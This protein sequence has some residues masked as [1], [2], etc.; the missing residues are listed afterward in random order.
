MESK[1][2]FT[3]EDV[4]VT[5]CHYAEQCQD[6]PIFYSEPLRVSASNITDVQPSVQLPEQ[7]SLQHHADEESGSVHVATP[8]QP[9]SLTVRSRDEIQLITRQREQRLQYQICEESLKHLVI[10]KELGQKLQAAPQC[11]RHQSP[12]CLPPL[13]LQTVQIRQSVHATSTN[14]GVMM[15]DNSST[16]HESPLQVLTKKLQSQRLQHQIEIEE[17]V[18]KIKMKG[19][20]ETLHYSN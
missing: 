4:G 15:N 3:N 13:C 5:E 17:A 8:E 6:H 20:T 16:E 2:T 19:L 1:Q 11:A 9:S 7:L 12:T 10:V 14:G 18:H